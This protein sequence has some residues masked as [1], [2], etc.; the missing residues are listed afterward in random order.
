MLDTQ[1]GSKQAVK[2]FDLK[3]DDIECFK[4]EVQL[5]EKIKSQPNKYI[6]NYLG[7]C[8]AEKR[9]GG[10]TNGSYSS[11]IMGYILMEKGKANLNNYIKKRAEVFPQQ[12]LIRFVQQMIEVHCHLQNIQIAHRDVKPDNIIITGE[13]ESVDFKVCD[14]GAGT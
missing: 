5:L 9:A 11:Q 8:I 14:V 4:N 7:Y 10:D 2:I 3:N 1:T 13:E 6:I 12:V